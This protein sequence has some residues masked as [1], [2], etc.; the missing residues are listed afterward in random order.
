MQTESD[1]P[2]KRQRRGPNEAEA[3]F[4]AVAGENGW[5]VT[6]RGW[7]DF[8]CSRGGKIMAVEVK[9]NEGRALRSS[10][11]H[12][13]EALAAAGIDCYRWS[14][15]GGFVRIDPPGETPDDSGGLKGEGVEVDSENQRQQ[16]LEGSG[17]P[18]SPFSK[19][20]GSD[21]KAMAVNL[22]WAHYVKVMEPRSDIAGEDARRIIR[23]AL[24]VATVEECKRAIDGCAASE[25]HMGKNERQKKYNKIGQILKGRPR[26][27]ET[28]RDRIDFFL[29]K[30]DASALGIAE[31]PS[32]D[33]AIVMQKV[34]EVRHAHR[35]PDDQEVVERAEQAQE[36]LQTH[37]IQ[38]VRDSDGFPRFERGPG[39]E[40][41]AA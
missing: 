5:E 13:M 4:A 17:E 7:P 27:N 35:V 11:Q 28:T 41:P 24:K 14:P 32:V 33:A 38:T 29:D 37:G 19:P 2:R 26:R 10:Q 36:W 16:V 31:I 6:K 25:F 20:E 3:E 15:D 1:E 8:F 23:N 18:F 22:V 21:A 39:A 30:A 12:V 9:P 40:A 34:S